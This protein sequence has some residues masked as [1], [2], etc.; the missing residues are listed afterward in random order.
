MVEEKTPPKFIFI[1]L[2]TR[3]IHGKK[4]V[5]KHRNQFGN[6]STSGDEFTKILQMGSDQM[7]DLELKQRGR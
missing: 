3:M 6:L 5:P 7:P 2:S 1:T 4:H